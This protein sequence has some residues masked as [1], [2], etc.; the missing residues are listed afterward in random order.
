MTAPTR[1]VGLRPLRPGLLARLLGW[2]HA[3]LRARATTR[4]I[5]ALR[6][7]RAIARDIGQPLPPLPER[8]LHDRW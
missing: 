1:I 2:A 6:H 5:A 7:D 4:R 3:R 8:P